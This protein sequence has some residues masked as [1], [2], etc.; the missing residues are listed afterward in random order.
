MVVQ[1]NQVNKKLSWK[2]RLFD[3]NLLTRGLVEDCEMDFASQLATSR[4]SQIAV[5]EFMH[6][7]LTCNQ[8]LSTCIVCLTPGSSPY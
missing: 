8:P 2:E 5:D 4:K 7:R 1:K 6:I 3:Q